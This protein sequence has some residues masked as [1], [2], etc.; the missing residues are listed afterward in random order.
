MT[1]RCFTQPSLADAL[2][3]PRAGRG[4]FLEDLSKTFDW[5]AVAA[6]FG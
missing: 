6:L 3:K 2:V 4:G 1:H 5:G